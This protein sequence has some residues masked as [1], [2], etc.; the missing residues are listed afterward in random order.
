M[1]IKFKPVFKDKVWGG[2]LLHKKFNYP[3][4]NTCGEVWG[5][6]AHKNGMS[7]VENGVFA[8]KT[9]QT[10]YSENPEL[11]GNFP[12]KDFPILIKIIHAKEDLS[13]QVHPDDIYANEHHRSKGKAECWYI[14][15]TVNDTDIVIGHN[16]KTK[17]DFISLMKKNNYSTLLKRRK[18]EKGDFFNI[19]PGTIHAICKNT[20]LLEVQQSSDVTYRLYDY[21]RLH[22]GSLRELHIDNAL[23]V[24]HYP[25]NN[26]IDSPIL[27]FHFDIINQEAEYMSDKYGDYLV[28]IDGEGLINNTS[29]KKGDFFMVTSD[30]LYTITKGLTVQRTRLNE[31]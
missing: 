25:D 2:N 28:V 10:L 1:I 16:A 24:I 12:D 23:D 15:D 14:L 11:F 27:Y 19:H 20:L 30:S 5:I 9:L 6:S 4:S 3:C 7:T 18:I 26:E 31:Q 29:C 8:G 21:N 17:S 22:N 13:I